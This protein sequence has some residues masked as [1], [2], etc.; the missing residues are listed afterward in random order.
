MYSNCYQIMG[1]KG[2][3]LLLIETLFNEY[4]QLAQK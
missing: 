2:R 3:Y 4:R 1:E